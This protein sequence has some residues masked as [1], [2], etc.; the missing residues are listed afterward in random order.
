MEIIPPTLN[1]LVSQWLA[2][3]EGEQAAVPKARD[4]P[5]P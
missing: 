1:F 2:F 5:A 3:I 4:L